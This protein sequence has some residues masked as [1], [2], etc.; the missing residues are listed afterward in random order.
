MLEVSMYLVKRAVVLPAFQE[1]MIMEADM[2]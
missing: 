2:S 1:M